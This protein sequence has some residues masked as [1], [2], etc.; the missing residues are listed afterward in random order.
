MTERDHRWEMK[1]A[2][3]IGQEAAT[4]LRLVRQLKLAGT[5]LGAFLFACATA[6]SLTVLIVTLPITLALML[7]ALAR[8]VSGW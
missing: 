8:E 3:F 4:P 2:S 7:V 6:L 1:A 5:G